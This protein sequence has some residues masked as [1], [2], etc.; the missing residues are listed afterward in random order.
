MRADS[1]ALL[2]RSIDDVVDTLPRVDVRHVTL[3]ARSAC[4]THVS[5]ASDVWRLCFAV[6]SQ[7]FVEHFE[8]PRVPCILT[9]ATDGW[10][11]APG[12]ARAWSWASLR[13]RF[14]EHKF[15]IGSDDDGY[16]V[17][18][19]MRH[20]VDYVLD[21]SGAGV[22]DSPLYVF[23]G[24]YGDRDGSKTLLHDYSVPPY[25]KEDLFGGVGEKRRPP[26]RWVVFGPARS[27]SSL[28]I[29][30]LATSAWNALLAGRKRW[31]LLPPGVPRVD[32]K[33]RI[34]G[35]TDGEAVTWFAHVLPRCM[36]P[37]W[38]HARP[39]QAIQR[40]GEIMY[41]PNGWWHAVL[42]LDHTIAVTQNFVSSSNF[43]AAWRHTRKA[44]PKLCERWRQFLRAQRP[45]LAAQA[46]SLDVAGID[47]VSESSPSSSSSSTDSSSSSDGGETDS[48]AAMDADAGKEVLPAQKSRKRCSEDAAPPGPP[49]GPPLFMATGG[50]ADVYAEHGASW[51]RRA[52]AAGNL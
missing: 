42:N 24:T 8:R 19:R 20:F 28:H 12:G 52:A 1:A 21:P 10:P 50:A 36:A 37:D 5:L 22:D 23:D 16:A 40:A 29:D 30:P 35:V 13:E 48:E 15:K 18:L 39:I 25:F 44:R 43:A 26:Y 32:C 11:A 7:E 47:D 31:V 49:P 9:H 45:D 6:C 46:E 51:R 34:P 17:R 41:V 3:E 33:P 2:A 4:L 38:P 27:G 14:G